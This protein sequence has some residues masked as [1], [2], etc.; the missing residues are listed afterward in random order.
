ML[1][2]AADRAGLACT[3][4]DVQTVATE[5]AQV[6]GVP[7]GMP[8]VVVKDNHA[9]AWRQHHMHTSSIYSPGAGYQQQAGKRR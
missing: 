7:R 5:G 1:L 3:V 4:T 8:T 9:C 6:I 2:P